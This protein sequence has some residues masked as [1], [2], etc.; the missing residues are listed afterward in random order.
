[1]N[2]IILEQVALYVPLMLGAYIAL[3][4]MKIPSLSI[5]SAYVFGAIFASR[6]IMADPRQDILVLIMALIA[7]FC[8]GALVGIVAA[9]LSQKAKFSHLLS[10]I[11]T[12]GFFYG[13][14]QWVIGGTHVTLPAQHN[15]L[16][17]FDLIPQYPE[18]IMV[19]LIS[20]FLVLFVAYF[21][22]T[23][24]GMSCAIYGDN[25]AFLNN[26]RINQSYVVIAGMAISNG[27]VG[28]SGYMIAQ[29]NGFVDNTMGAGIP[30]L[31]ISALIVGKALCFPS[32]KMINVIIPLVGAV[33]YFLIQAGLLKVGFDLRY[34][35]S[36]Q[37][38]IVACL[39]LFLSRFRVGS[40]YHDLLGI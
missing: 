27:L 17:F 8:G 37:A 7:S 12:I 3:G 36:V 39:L 18:L 16:R 4:L 25:P 30:L 31:C 5:E 15:P 14:A 32:K 21:L 22:Q 23:E 26:Y 33:G 9:L 28:I 38:V 6:I 10:A 1:M 20:M 29:S 40:S 24:L 19:A 13:V 34:F 11:I 2:F 35:T